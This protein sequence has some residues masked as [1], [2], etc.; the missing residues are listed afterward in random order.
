MAAGCRHAFEQ[1]F[2]MNIC[3]AL[4]SQRQFFERYG[5]TAAI[6]IFAT[7]KQQGAYLDFED[8]YRH[9]RHQAAAIRKSHLRRIDAERYLLLIY[10]I[11]APGR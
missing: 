9:T 2:D 5:K 4:N 1:L 3:N 10:E 7:L 11:N 6:I 8:K